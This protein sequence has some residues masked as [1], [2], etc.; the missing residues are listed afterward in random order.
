MASPIP[1][2]EP[3]K[4]AICKIIS[5]E[6]LR[7]QE[8]AKS[9]PT[10]NPAHIVKTLELNWAIDRNDLSHRLNKM[11]QFLEKGNRVEVMLATKRKGRRATIEEAES[12]LELVR[13]KVGQVEG[14][15][16]WKAMQGRVLTP[17]VLFF[18]GKVQ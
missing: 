14:A 3:N 17:S 1:R 10:K 16:E 4:P 5:K 9:K 18:E 13:E 7:E 8:R 15:K 11:V 12:V 6:Q 2:K